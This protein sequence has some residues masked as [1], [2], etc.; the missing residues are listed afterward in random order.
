MLSARA[1][2]MLSLLKPYQAELCGDF[3]QTCDPAVFADIPTV[4]NLCLQRWP[5]WQRGKHWGLWCCRS[6]RG[7]STTLNCWRGRRTIS[8][9]CQSSLK[10]SSAWRLPPRNAEAKKEEDEALQLCLL[11]KPLVHP[12]LPQCK[13][14]TSVVPPRPAIPGPEACEA[15]THP[16][17]FIW[18]C[19]AQP[20]TGFC[21]SP[22][23]T[24]GPGCFI[25]AQ[26]EEERGLTGPLSTGDVAN[27]SPFSSYTG[28]RL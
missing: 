18:L 26:E 10:G 8:W 7:A 15:G 22:A 5:S 11:W 23:G 19:L 24:T 13:V 28:S 2:N 17:R 20:S 9:I 12:Q 25:P 4:A 21:R 16:V 1:L 27:D 3:A 14:F 6:T